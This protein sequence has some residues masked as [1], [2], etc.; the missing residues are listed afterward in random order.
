[1]VGWKLKL[2]CDLWTSGLLGCWYDKMWFSLYLSYLGQANLAQRVG[3]DWA[4][5]TKTVSQGHSSL[6]SE[7]EIPTHCKEKMPISVP[8]Q[9][10]PN[11]VGKD[12]WCR[13]MPA[14]LFTDSSAGQRKYWFTHI[15][16]ITNMVPHTKGQTGGLTPKRHTHKHQQH[17]TYSHRDRKSQ[18]V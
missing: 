16:Q 1:M 4:T 7:R 3:H 12:T 11:A 15:R 17:T 18:K 14:P 6:E 8:P 13:H 5:F 9:T 10:K 2:L